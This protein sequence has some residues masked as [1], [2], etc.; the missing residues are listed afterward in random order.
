MWI[1]WNCKLDERYL[2]IDKSLQKKHLLPIAIF[3]QTM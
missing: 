2:F 3:L 1:I